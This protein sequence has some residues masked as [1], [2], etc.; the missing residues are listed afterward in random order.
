MAIMANQKTYRRYLVLWVGQKT[1]LLGSSI[2]QFAIIW[3]ITL[4]TQNALYLALA[5]LLGFGTQ[6]ILS[7]LAGVYADRW[8]R[9]LIIGIT[10]LFQALATIVLIGL[11]FF[12]AQQLWHIFALLT[13]R[14]VLQA[15]QAPTFGAIIPTMVPK[16][17]LGFMNSINFLFVGIIFLLGPVI[18]AI[19]LTLWPIGQIL[20]VDTITFGIAIVPLLLINIPSVRN[21]DA[22]QIRSSFIKEFSEGL[23]VIK[24]TRGFTA[25][26]LTAM[27]INFL[28]VPLNTLMPYYIN[29]N[30]FGVELDLAFVMALQ[31]F[32][33]IVGSLFMAL[34]KDFSRKVLVMVISVYGLFFGYIMAALAPTGAIW[35]IAL[36][37]LIIGTIIPILNIT[38]LTIVQVSI[39][40]EMQGRINSVIIALSNAISPLGMIY[41]GVF[42]EAIG[43]VPLFLISAFIGI[44]TTTVSWLFTDM[45][46]VLDMENIDESKKGKTIE[47]LTEDSPTMI[48][49]NL[50]SSEAESTIA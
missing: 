31:Q 25:T 44:L 20:W 35:T 33:V 11:F 5:S 8:N 4:I 45:R 21:Q 15:F 48:Q 40:L 36:G 24:K 6:V 18:S 41:A 16:E 10:D 12:Q 23:T 14:G 17:K 50:E 37:L 29:V 49:M 22:K 1:S 38:I 3:Y 13:V 47:N 7:P 42:A 2:V 28:L 30:H 32:G 26:L 43:V 27:A 39:P 46:H 19:L 34:K 9:K